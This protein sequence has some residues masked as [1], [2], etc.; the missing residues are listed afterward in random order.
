MA[1]LPSDLAL[2]ILKRQEKLVAKQ[3]PWVPTWRELGE[4]ISPR[5]TNS[6]TY[7][8]KGS[9]QTSKL[10]DSTALDSAT[11][12]S[13]NMQGSLTS[14][15]SRWFSMV[16]AKR[17]LNDLKEARDWLEDSSVRIY[18]MY[19]E[20]NFY[21]EVAE[22]YLDLAVFSTA[23]ILQ[24][25]RGNAV[26][27]TS[28]F[29]GYLFR[30]LSIGEYSVAEDAEG[31]VDTV[32]RKFKLTAR[33]MV[34]EFG[35]QM[36]SDKVR[37]KAESDPDEEFEIV[38]AVYPRPDIPRNV[39]GSVLGPKRPWASVYVE[40]GSKRL[41]KNTGF[42]TFPYAAPR[43]AKASG[44]EYGRGPGFD[45]IPDV[46]TL[47]RSVEMKLKAWAKILDPP[48]KVRDKGVIGDTRTGAGGQTSVR[49]MD[50]IAPLYEV[51][52]RF[53]V[54]N[55]EEEKLKT[56]IRAI[57]FIDQLQLRDGPMMTA[58]ESRIRFELMQRILGPTLGRLQ[59]ELLGPII[60]RSFDLALRR[61]AL[62]TPPDIV[63]QMGR[64]TLVR[65]ENPLSRAQ[66]L[67]EVEAV[68]RYISIMAPVEQ[69][70][71][72]VADNVDYDFLARNTAEVV[73]VPSKAIRDDRDVEA[74]RAKRSEEQAKAAQQQ[75][76]MQMAEAAGKAAPLIAASRGGGGA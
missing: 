61:G 62:A 9:K 12:L 22:V 56:A 52:S 14:A 26:D 11:K 16:Y 34:A 2:K 75:Q 63:L 10:F 33:T 7:R 59:A 21:S 29:G 55:L 19:S 15:A 44:E 1:V 60:N 73:G 24:E 49:D 6:L 46:R 4:F 28:P 23:A 27:E 66:R 32:F 72:E 76:M 45:A 18:Q 51:G 25:E 40:V 68:Q 20:S 42:Y 41:L 57:F 43:W 48:L 39:E 47:N 17:E 36:V 69:A 65:Y 3:Q 30:A 64:D 13:A 5:K 8:S 58:E 70:H 71:P 53:N 37:E 54:T 31:Y 35:E 74:I 38:H 50:A 67:G